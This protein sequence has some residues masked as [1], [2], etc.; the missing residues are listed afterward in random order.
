MPNPSA[1]ISSEASSTLSLW[2]WLVGGLGVLLLVALGYFYLK[3][4]LRSIPEHEVT[5]S[6]S[7][8]NPDFVAGLVGLTGAV[9]TTGNLIGFWREID[10]IYAAR[11]D[12]IRRAEQLVQYETYFMTPGKRADAFADAVID[13]ALAGV[14]VQLLLDHQGS[15][16]ISQD[17]WRR[18]KNVGIEIH[19][20]RQPDWR[21]PLEYNS[22]SHRK[23]LI[24][25]GEQIFIGGAGISDYWDGTE[26]DHDTAPWL[27]FEVAYE[28]EIVTLLQGKFWQNW[29]Y[30]GGTVDLSQFSKN[31]QVSQTETPQ[32]EPPQVDTP[33]AD[34]PQTLYITDDTSTLNESP[35]RMLV[36]LSTLAAQERLWIGSPYFVPDSNTTHAMIQAQENGVDVRV[37]T[38][39]AA[40][41]KPMVHWASREL[42]GPLLRAGITLC[43]YQPSMMHAKFI[44]ADDDWVSTGSANL[45]PRSYFHNDELNV[46][47][48]HAPLAQAVEQF[49]T[50][51]IADSQC[52]SYA[53][54]QAR[55]LLERLAGRFALLGKN[56]L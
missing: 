5:N 53:D 37:L 14:T 11:T 17:Y 22:R 41:D 48:F 42:Y 10:Q 40:T 1:P 32:A 16:D 51:A 44:L 33:Q 27:D 4:G 7:I 55:P 29:A 18:L 20:F 46:S 15:Q 31:G 9:T 6:P 39:G 8:D 28:G 47:G 21:A 38:M 34:S 52:L 23:L 24:I 45:D 35:T 3:G 50:D 13:R 12:A 56:L 19:F 25:D 49:V 30:T 43:E 36:Q 54:W 2:W 26:F